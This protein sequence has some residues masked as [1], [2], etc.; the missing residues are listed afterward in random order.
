MSDSIRSPRAQ[1]PIDYAD[2]AKSAFPLKFFTGRPS[3][4][5]PRVQ[6]IS[7][8]SMTPDGSG[9]TEAHF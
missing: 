3:T 7:A 9:E 8:K 4:I 1:L 2:R 6:T 5:S